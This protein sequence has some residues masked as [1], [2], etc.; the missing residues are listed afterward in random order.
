MTR[1]SLFFTPIVPLSSLTLS[2]PR[3]HHCLLLHSFTFSNFKFTTL[4]SETL[5]PHLSHTHCHN[6]P[7]FHSH[8]YIGSPIL[9]A[10][11]LRSFILILLQARF[12]PCPSLWLGFMAHIYGGYSSKKVKPF[13]SFSSSSLFLFLFFVFFQFRSKFW[14]DVSLLMENERKFLI[15]LMVVGNWGDAGNLCHNNQGQRRL[16][17][18]EWWLTVVTA[19]TEEGGGWW[20]LV[21]GS[22]YNKRFNLFSTFLLFSSFHFFYISVLTSIL[23]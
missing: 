13:Y 5:I 9:T 22:L 10:I 18:K 6:T 19:T 15:S 4:I 21:E 8:C 20:I 7:L 17:K 16:I 1:V 2:L 12:K 23:L 3:L 11:T 14:L